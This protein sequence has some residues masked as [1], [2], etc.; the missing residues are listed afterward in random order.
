MS[1]FFIAPDVPADAISPDAVIHAGCRLSGKTLSIGP[2][3]VVGEEG[4]VTLRDCQLGHNVK[5]AGGFFDHSTF[6]DNVSGGDQAHVRPAC[7]FEE[8]VSFGH[9]C[10][11]K[12]TILLPFVTTGSLINFCDLLMGGGTSRANHSE[13]GSSYIH[14]NFTPHQDKAT[15]SLLGDV[16]RGVFLDQPPIFLGGQGGLVGPRYLT[17]GT[18]IPAGQIGRRDVTTENRLVACKPL[19]DLDMAYPPL[20]RQNAVHIFNA[21]LTFIANL[22]A[23]DHWHRHIRRPFMA[24]DPWR[25]RC[26]AGALQRI[27]QALDER[28]KRLTHF[29]ELL[30]RE[31]DAGQ[32]VE[33]RD[34]LARWPQLRDRLAHAVATRENLP[35]PPSSVSGAAYIPAIQSLSAEQKAP[36]RHHLQGIVRRIVG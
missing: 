19:P 23:L 18:L 13:V 5:L 29:C 3:C 15:A 24:T 14:F 25:N 22:V 27:A 11:F 2:G 16:P 20:H 9:C 33:T 35:P 21:N 26:H 30:A 10:G 12:Q 1:K 32:P 36:L 4:P 34:L 8:D 7:L 17:F 28:L 31:P 6:L